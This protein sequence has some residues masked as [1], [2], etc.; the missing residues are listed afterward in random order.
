MSAGEKPHFMIVRHYPVTPI[1]QYELKTMPLSGCGMGKKSNATQWSDHSISCILLIRTDV[2]CPNEN[3][4]WPDKETKWDCALYQLKYKLPHDHFEFLEDN[5]CFMWHQCSWHL[6]PWYAVLESGQI[7]Q[8]SIT[9]F[10]SN[11]TGD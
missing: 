11:S 1:V 6:S 7:N 5:F 10:W 2:S 3:C 9:A 4:S 8:P